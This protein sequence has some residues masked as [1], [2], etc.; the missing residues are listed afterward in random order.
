M[1]LGK[2]FLFYFHRSL[3]YTEEWALPGR[4]ER[5]LGRGFFF[6]IGFWVLFPFPLETCLVY[7]SNGRGH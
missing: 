3:T 5:W 7:K 6:Q 4:F 2:T 1:G